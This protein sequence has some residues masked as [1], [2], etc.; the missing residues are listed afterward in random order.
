M[1]AVVMISVAALVACAPSKT[2]PP[3]PAA[4]AMQVVATADGVPPSIDPRVSDGVPLVPKPLPGPPDS[5]WN[6]LPAAYDSLGIKLN[7]VDLKQHLIGNQGMKLRQKLGST[8]LSKYLDC[9]NAQ[10]G[11]SADSYDVLMSVMAHVGVNAE[12]W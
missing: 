9:G 11:P 12:G 2:S 8:R 3:A 10:I 6:A 5:V 7:V 4:S 1:R